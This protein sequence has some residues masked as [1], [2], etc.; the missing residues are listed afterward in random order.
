[1]SAYA[2]FALVYSASN[3]AASYPILAS[4]TGFAVQSSTVAHGPGGKASASGLKV[5]F[6]KGSASTG[7]KLQKKSL[8]A[9]N[10]TTRDIVKKAGHD[11]KAGVK[12]AGS[13]VKAA[14]SPSAKESKSTSPLAA[15]ALLAVTEGE[16]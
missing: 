10:L 12:A 9:A 14:L 7:N 11:L 8:D 15:D 13:K 5:S 1:M 2:A 6:A 3:A 4:N 16:F